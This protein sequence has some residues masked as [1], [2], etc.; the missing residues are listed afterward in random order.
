[1]SEPPVYID[2]PG[3]LI[4]AG[5][6]MTEAATMHA[7]F[8]KGDRHKQQALIDRALNASSGETLKFV[9]VTDFVMLACLNA[10]RT[11]SLDPVDRLRGAAAE[12]DV[13]FWALVFG[14]P[15]SQPLKWRA[16][17]FPVFLF[18]GNAS[19]LASG[20]EVYGYPKTL[21]YFT[22]KGDNVRDPRQ[23]VAAEHI[24]AFSEKAQAKVETIFTIEG[25]DPVVA[26]ASLAAVHEHALRE[27]GLIAEPR[28][29]S[30]G[31]DVAALRLGLPTILLK[32]IADADNPGRACHRSIVSLQVRATRIRAAG[33]ICSALSVGFERSAS[34]PIAETLGLAKHAPARL[35]FWV[36]MD[37]SVPPGVTLWRA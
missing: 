32:Q 18:V 26:Y 10:E 15:A 3:R 17:W 24:V 20:R 16:Y 25:A 34:F 5:P 31:F 29:A 8:L 35:A 36:D 2:V 7:L 19:A 28:A 22:P 12:I 23:A 11:F 9:A 33:F 4:G 13:G 6:Y 21:G 30:M 27:T 37:F 14:G 1:M